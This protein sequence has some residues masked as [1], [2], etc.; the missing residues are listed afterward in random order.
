MYITP[1]AAYT[2]NAQLPSNSIRIESQLCVLVFVA[3]TSVGL[4]RWC[5]GGVGYLYSLFVCL[6]V[7]CVDADV[8]IVGVGHIVN[9]GCESV[10]MF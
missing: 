3:R 4:G 7:V 2:Y 1:T 8:V 10:L 6:W 5:V 9:Y